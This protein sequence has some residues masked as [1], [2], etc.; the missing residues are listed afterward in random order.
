MSDVTRV[1][2]T[3]LAKRTQLSPE[4]SA[5][6]GVSGID[7]SGKGYITRQIS[8]QLQPHGVR[9]STI[10]ADGWLTLP[11]ER[12]RA[13]HPAENFYEHAFRFDDMFRQL[14]LPLKERRTI[15][16]VA[17]F[18]EETDQAYRKH[19]Y[20]FEDIDIILLEGAYLLK[21]AYRGH[22]DLSLWVDCSFET[23]LERALARRQEHLPPEATIRAYE[24]IYFPAQRIHFARD[25]PR[26]A[27]DG[28]INNDPRLTEGK[29]AT[30]G[31]EAGPVP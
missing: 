21:K 13:D 17:D 26:A 23:A 15:H 27:A 30:P 5:L 3:I 9:T 4:R 6:V 29:A 24:T 11:H 19:N 18:T 1:A 7:G 20:D 28:I 10:H 8:E 31:M 16:L 25:N 22:F 14:V 12:L 2:A